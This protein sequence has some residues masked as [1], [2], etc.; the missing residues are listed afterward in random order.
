M[1]QRIG[2]GVDVHRLAPGETLWLGGILI[3]SDLGTVAHS[4]GD[5]L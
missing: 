4:D 5:V 1:G 3:P 2:F